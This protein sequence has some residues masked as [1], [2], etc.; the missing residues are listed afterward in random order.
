MIKLRHLTCLI[1]GLALVACG[2]S[3][4][5]NDDPNHAT[6]SH[7]MGDAKQSHYSSLKQITT[8]NVNQLELAWSYKS[9]GVPEKGNSQIQTNPL[10]VN[11]VLF[12]VNAAIQLFA[13]D[14]TTGEELWK[15]TPK[16]RD[17]SGLGLNRGLTFG[18][19]KTI[20][21]SGYIFLWGPNYTQ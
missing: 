7:Y 15:F 6:W 10:I 11:N 19:Q 16:V 18:N 5:S 12:G 17:H 20:R 21:T 13:V 14:A 8:E 9:G 4:Q 3:E 2:E 1:S